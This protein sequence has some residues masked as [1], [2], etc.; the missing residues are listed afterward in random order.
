MKSASS[1][2]DALIGGVAGAFLLPPVKAAL[3]PNSV[4]RVSMASFARAS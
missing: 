4:P 3:V 1:E 2:L